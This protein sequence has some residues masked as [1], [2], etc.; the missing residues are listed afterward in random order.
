MDDQERV[1]HAHLA[2]APDAASLLAAYAE[3]VE[4]LVAGL[5]PCAGQLQLYLQT[6]YQQ[7]TKLFRNRQ[8]AV[9]LTYLPY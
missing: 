2:L 5:S 1:L 9:H 7:E 8:S 4:G 3:L 6:A